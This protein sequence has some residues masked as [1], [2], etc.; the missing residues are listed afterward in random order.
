M[1]TRNEGHAV[2][3]GRKHGGLQKS[4]GLDNGCFALT[5]R[6]QEEANGFSS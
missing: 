6:L 2:D 4:H 3:H 1:S 5:G